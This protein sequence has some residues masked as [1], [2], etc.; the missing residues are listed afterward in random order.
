MNLPSDF[1]GTLGL[2]KVHKLTRSLYGLKQSPGAW[3]NRF[4]KAIKSYG[5]LQ[6]QVDHTM[7]YKHAGSGQV[8]VLIMYVNDI[9]LTSDDLVKQEKLKTF[10]AK[11]FEIKDLG[12]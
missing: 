8:L 9:I 12:L 6:S 11:E 5:Y 4:T 7:F 2:G 3:F 10:L 1:E